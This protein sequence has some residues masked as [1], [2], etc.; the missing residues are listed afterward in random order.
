MTIVPFN[1]AGSAIG[2]EQTSFTTLL[3]C[4]PIEDPT[5]GELVSFG[6]EID[7]PGEV[8]LCLNE[9][10]TIVTSEVVADGHRWY[11][12]NDDGTETLLS[13]TDELSLFEEGQYRYEAYNSVVQLGDTFECA[14]SKVFFVSASEIPRITGTNVE[15]LNGTLRI[16]VKTSGIGD[17]EY[18][19]GSSTGPYQTSNIFENIPQGSH[20]VYVRDKNG[21]GIA[22]ERISGGLTLENFPTFF[23]PNGDGI[24]DFWQFTPSPEI[25]GP[26]LETIYIFNRYGVLLAQ[27]GPTSQGWDG[28]WQGFPLPSSD[29]WFKAVSLNKKEVSGHFSL[30]R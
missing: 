22:E 30:K 7:F 24:N 1:R 15:E 23:T 28:N 13:E 2:C 26:I 9:N 6:P 8:A 17:Y 3:G 20:V 14:D 27:I 5:T 10:P 29:Y 11:G 16:T 12:I 21:C 19:I 18:A 4:G 25:T